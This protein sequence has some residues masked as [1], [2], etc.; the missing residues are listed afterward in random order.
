MPEKILSNS[1]LEKMVE[2]TDKWIV[3]R[4]GVKERRIASVDEAVSDL[5]LKASKMALKSADINPKSLDLILL[6]TITGDMPLPASACYLQSKL[7]A[8]N[9]AAFDLN[10]ACSGFIYGLSVAY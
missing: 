8:D 6:A 2:T 9:A 4:T 5:A 7:S 10:A 1:D 3:E